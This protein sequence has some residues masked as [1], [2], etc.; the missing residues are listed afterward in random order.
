MSFRSTLA[1]GAAVAMLLSPLAARAEGLGFSAEIDPLPFL[2]GGYSVGLGWRLD[3]L[4]LSAHAFAADVPSFAL[5][6]GF[7]AHI[8]SG[9]ALRA[10]LYLSPR[11]RGWFAGAEIGPTSIR[12]TKIGGEGVARVDHLSFTPTAGLR[13]F[14]SG[15]GLYFMPAVGVELPL[16]T[17]GDETLGGKPVPAQRATPIAALHLGWEL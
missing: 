9:Y 4:R 17:R 5:P 14:P 10:Q 1:T 6:S 3:R 11:A 15:E 7:R 13:W 12:Y 16:R 2:A 8:Q